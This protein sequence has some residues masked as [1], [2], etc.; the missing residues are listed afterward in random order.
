MHNARL[1]RR[2]A[3][4]ITGAIA[5]AGALVAG[6]RGGALADGIPMQGAAVPDIYR[7]PL[8]DA[9]VTTVRDGT[10]VG[11]EPHKTYGIDMPPEEVQELLR[12]NFLPP[13]RFEN[14]FTPTLLNTGSELVLFDSG[15]GAGRRPDTGQ[16]RQRL[17]DAGVPPEA[18]TVVVLTHFHP[19]H[20]GG[21]MEDGA[22]AFPNARYV[23]PAAE[24]DF[25]SPPEKAAAE[26]TARV[27]QIV[28]SNVVP[29]AEKTTFV[30]PGDTA[31]PGVT[32]IDTHGHT[33]GHL[34]YMIDS[35]GKQLV[36]SGDVANH[37]VLSVQRPDWHVRFDMDK[38]AAVASRQQLLGM[39]AADRIPFVGY[40]MPYPS[41]G[42]V[43]AV[44]DGFRFVPVTYQLR[45]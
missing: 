42:F 35:G 7:F 3:F 24:Y 2:Q 13:D 25:W 28:Q 30:K 1:T 38:E 15:N 21:L 11:E 20:I 4:A 10:V 40:H 34:S 16:M 44:G 29:L 39:L 31:A 5:G 41:V 12:A 19:D 18:I 6:G 23:A 9:E 43:E 26:A 33:P 45:V 14:G 36:V 27:G 17:A 37:Y 32:A 8:G 22:P